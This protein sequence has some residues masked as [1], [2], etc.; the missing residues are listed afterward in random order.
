VSE[1]RGRPVL[2]YDGACGF[3]TRSVE[4]AISRLDAVVDYEPYQT[5][6][7]GA[8]GISEA[9]ASHSL[10]WVARNGRIGQG[11]AAVARLLMASGGLFAPLGRLLLVPPVSWLAELVYRAVA[12]VRHHLPGVTPALHRPPDERP[13]CRSGLSRHGSPAE[14]QDR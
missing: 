13:R 3:C 1:L 2:V 8:L 6:D 12:D 14:R 4:A 9:E 10:Q 11:S 7:L 5:T